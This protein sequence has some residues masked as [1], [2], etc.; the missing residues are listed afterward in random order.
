VAS[1]AGAPADIQPFESAPLDET[2]E[3]KSLIPTEAEPVVVDLNIGGS[4]PDLAPIGSPSE[5]EDLEYSP[6]G[7]RADSDEL[8]SG[9]AETAE[10][11]VADP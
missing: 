8:S 5:G 10:T 3:F 6:K 9:E 11:N 4:G 7:P 1:F 2:E